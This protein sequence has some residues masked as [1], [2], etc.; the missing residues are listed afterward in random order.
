ML[1]FICG[2]YISVN[3]LQSLVIT[4][5]DFEA[6]LQERKPSVDSIELQSYADWNNKFGTGSKW[7]V[8]LDLECIQYSYYTCF[9]ENISLEGKT[10]FF[11]RRVGEYQRS[12]VMHG[13]EDNFVF[14]TDA[15]FWAPARFQSFFLPCFAPF[16]RY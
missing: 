2:L 15:D 8:K 10:N 11:E 16:Y 1:Q 9:M 6:A 3:I 4:A 12:N 13:R 14:T 7:F 5:A